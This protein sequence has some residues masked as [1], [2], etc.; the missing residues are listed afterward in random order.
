MVLGLVT[1]GVARAVDRAAPRSASCIVTALGARGAIMVTGSAGRAMCSWRGP[2]NYV[3]VEVGGAA[4][5]P[6]LQSRVLIL[7]TMF[8]DGESLSRGEVIV[9]KPPISS[10][11][12][13]IKRVI[14]LPG[15]WIRIAPDRNGIGHVFIDS[16]RPTGAGSG[17]ELNEPYVNGLWR[18]EVVCCTARGQASPVL[19]VTGRWARIPAD[20]YFVMGDNRNVSE[21][22]RTFGWE[23][24][25]GIIAVVRLRLHLRLRAGT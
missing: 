19:P 1:V 7:A 12:D 21:D 4:M 15:E 3:V 20:D 10:Q 2:L 14:G 22:S 23:P 6:T 17:E 13:F 25:S 5:Y 24:Q 11:T 16:H 8:S 18:Q 9:I